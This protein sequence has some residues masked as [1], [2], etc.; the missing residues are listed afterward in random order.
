MGGRFSP[1]TSYHLEFLAVVGFFFLINWVKL[2]AMGLLHRRQKGATA[3]GL[4]IV[5]TDLPCKGKIVKLV[6]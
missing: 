1:P 5:E 6:F 3:E 2:L 4:Q